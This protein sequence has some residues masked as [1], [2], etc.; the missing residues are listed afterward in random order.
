MLKRKAISGDILSISLIGLWPLDGSY[1][2]GLKLV[3]GGQTEGKMLIEI[4]DE[5]CAGSLTNIDSSGLGKWSLDCEQTE[6]ARGHFSWDQDGT[7][8]FRGETS[9]SG[10]AID[11]SAHPVF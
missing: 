4:N 7:L 1:I 3:A 9:Q 8:S 11:W 5:I 10:Q 2:S 6:D